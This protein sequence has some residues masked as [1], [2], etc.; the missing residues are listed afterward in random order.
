MAFPGGGPGSAYDIGGA[1]IALNAGIH[2]E[3]NNGVPLDHTVNILL[4]LNSNQTFTV[5]NPGGSF[6][7]GAIDLNGK[8]L[9][10]NI[11]ASSGTEVQGVIGGAGGLIKTNDGTLVLAGNNTYSGSTALDRGTLQINGSQPA[12]AVVLGAGTLKGSGTVGTLTSVGSGGPGSIVVSP[13]GSPG[14]LTCSN[15][16]LNS[17]TALAL[18]LNGT[19]PG[20]GYDRIAVN[21]S[22]S[23]GDA[24]LSLTLGFTPA[25]GN[26]FTL[27]SND[28]ADAVGGTFSGLP[29]GTIFTNSGALFQITYAGGDGND[30]VLARVSPPAQL[31]GIAAQ[32]NGVTQIQGIGLSNLAY[33]I[34]A[35]T[36]L[37][38]LNVWSNLGQ[39]T[40]NSNGLFTFTDTN[41]PL[42]PTRFYRALSP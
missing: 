42:F 36:S 21:G 33:T 20:F 16:A 29:E 17:S 5:H 6:Y 23:L 9:T 14:T 11:G 40:A 4:L 10:F 39:A 26:T 37:N 27:I 30:V 12:S 8:E 22:V 41:A 24:G 31:T 34:Q 13:G 19:A 32:L 25:V 2:V 18:E 35:A 28:G 7:L 1:S 38:P 3:N 15:V